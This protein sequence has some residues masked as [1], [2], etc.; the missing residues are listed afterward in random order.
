MEKMADMAWRLEEYMNE[1][2]SN[3]DEASPNAESITA[4]GGHFTCLFCDKY[5]WMTLS[6]PCIA[7][8]IIV[9][10][11]PIA[12]NAASCLISHFYRNY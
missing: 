8:K 4:T 6:G 12:K 5:R 2:A 3:V 7:S 10:K 11:C 9:S 1:V